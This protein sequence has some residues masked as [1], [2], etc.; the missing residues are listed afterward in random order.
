L[1]ISHSH[2]RLVPGGQVG[3]GLESSGMYGLELVTF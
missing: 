1:L 2:L 3:G